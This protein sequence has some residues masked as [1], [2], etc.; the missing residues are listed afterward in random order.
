MQNKFAFFSNFAETIRATIPAN[1]QAEA[2]QAICEYG[3]YGTLPEDPMLKM[4][5]LMAKSSI[6]NKGGAPEGNQ[7]AR[8]TTVETTI[9]Q[10]KTTLNNPETTPLETETRNKKQ[11]TET[12]V[13]EGQL[14]LEDCIAE[15]EKTK[16]DYSAEFEKW[17]AKYPNKKS[18]QD[19]LKS[20]NRVLKDKLAT[21]DELMRGL[22]AYSN[23]C[24]AKNTEAHYIK[25]PSTWLNQ[26]CWSDE[27]GVAVVEEFRPAVDTE[28][29][30]QTARM[31]ELAKQRMMEQAKLKYG[32]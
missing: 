19:A 15:K 17:W 2:Y 12:E 20:F 23:D 8:K 26:G 13:L 14:D 22:E 32:A 5:C 4:M 30:N 31:A 6:Y 1:K 16:S 29:L 10:P 3:I 21:F 25:H 24:K 18:K 11:E 7:N 9:K 28:K 27:Y